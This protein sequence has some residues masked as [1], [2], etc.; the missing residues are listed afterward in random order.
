MKT[1]KEILLVVLISISALLDL[2][3]AS[4]SIYYLIQ[5]LN[6]S[7]N[8]EGSATSSAIGLTTSAIFTAMFSTF[9]YYL[10]KELKKDLS[11]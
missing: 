2:W 9:V 8:M 7:Y 5:M 11:S 1:A 10:V 6:R 4:S 3:S